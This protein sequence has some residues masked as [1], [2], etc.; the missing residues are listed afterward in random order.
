M[1]S[2]LRP[3][4]ADATGAAAAGSTADAAGAAFRTHLDEF[5][6]GFDADLAA[7]LEERRVTTAEGP[8][9]AGDLATTLEEFVLRGGKRLRPALVDWAYRACGG[10]SP[11]AVRP[12]SMA[13]ELLHTYLLIHDDVMDHAETRR[14]GPAAHAEYRRRHEEGGWHGASDHFGQSVALLLG[15]LAHSWAV[16]LYASTL[17]AGGSERL[18]RTFS[19]M[20]HEVIVG[21]YLEFTVPDRSAPT[22][23]E[24]LRILQMKSGRYS[25]ERPIQLGASL[26]DAPPATLAALARYGRATGEAFQ[27]RDDL[28]GVFGSPEKTGKPVGSDLEE[29]K[30]TLLIFHALQRLSEAGRRELRTALGARDLEPE[31]M[32]RVLGLL[33][34][35]GA[36]RVVSEMIDTRL[37]EAREALGSAAISAPERALFRGLVEYLRERDR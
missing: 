14:G 9:G 28:L 19:E 20:S 7:W 37:A 22:E 12:L 31:R 36:R 8:R 35:S 11:V 1:A 5:R 10:D 15:D 6:A 18:H 3:R 25:V 30:Y 13:V 34:E 27:L 2:E 32:R 23:E 29:G 16:E 24:L 26:A 17:A 33:E 4:P 21:Q